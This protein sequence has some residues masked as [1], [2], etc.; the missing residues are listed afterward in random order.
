MRQGY[1]LSSFLFPLSSFAQCAK[2]Q[3]LA[4]G[5]AGDETID[6]GIEAGEEG[7]R[8]VPRGVRGDGKG[9]G[10]VGLQDPTHVFFVLFYIISTRT[11]Y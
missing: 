5:D 1:S 2:E 11:I 8:D 9:L 6:G 4:A 7:A 3:P 10:V